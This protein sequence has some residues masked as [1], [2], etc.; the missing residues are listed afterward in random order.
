[1]ELSHYIRRSVKFL[2]HTIIIRKNE[3]KTPLL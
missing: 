3:S 1:M 2:V